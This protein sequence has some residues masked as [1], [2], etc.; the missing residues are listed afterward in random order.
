GEN[1]KTD[2]SI[3]QMKGL[4]ST[5]GKLDGSNIVKLDNTDAYWDVKTSRTLIPQETMDKNRLALQQSMNMDPTTVTRYND[6]PS[7]GRSRSEKTL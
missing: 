7:G 2:L 3:D 4:A 6:S 1:V 5:F